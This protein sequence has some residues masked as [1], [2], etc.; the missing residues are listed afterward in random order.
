MHSS[1]LRRPK[2]EVCR[3]QGKPELHSDQSVLNNQKACCIS[4]IFC[5]LSLL[6]ETQPGAWRQL[7]RPEEGSGTGA[8]RVPV[9][10]VVRTGLRLGHRRSF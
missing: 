4:E 3:F 5:H 9:M 10:T 1:A 2:R 7:S 8:T 6:H